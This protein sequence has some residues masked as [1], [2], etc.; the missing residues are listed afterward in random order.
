MKGETYLKELLGNMDMEEKA[1][2]LLQLTGAYYSGSG[3]ETGPE[4][5]M[6][7]PEKMVREAGSILNVSGASVLK[8]VQKRYLENS[9][10]KIPLLFMA[11]VINGYR[12]VMPIALAQSCTF[13]PELV[14]K[15]ARMA[16]REAAADGLHVT[17][18]PM[19]DLC[20]DARWG[21]VM[22]SSGEDVWLN[23][24]MTK[25][26]VEGYQGD[27]LSDKGTLASCPKH[28]AAYGAPEGGREYDSVDMSEKKLRE[29]YLEGY[30][31][32]VEAGCEMMMTSFNTLNGIP[33]SANKWLN[34]KILREEWGFDGVLISDYSAL[35]ELIVHGVAEDEEQAAKLA[36]EAGVD[37]DMVSRVYA[38]ALTRL[39]GEGKLQEEFLDEAVLR[40]LRLKDKLGLFENPYRYSDEQIEEEQACIG[41]KEHRDLAR[42]IAEE[43]FVLL[44]NEGILPI[45]PEK[46]QRIALIGPYADVRDLCGSWSI[47]RREEDGISLKEAMKN[48]YG[49]EFVE[50][51]QG[52]F[53]LDEEEVFYSFRSKELTGKGERNEAGRTDEELLAEAMKTAKKADVIVV[54]IGEH[55]QK[56]GEGSAKSSLALP[57]CQ[58]E[59]LKAAASLGKP[60]AA[61]VFSGRPVELL[62]VTQ[63]ADAVLMAWFPGTEGGPALANVISG[64][65][66]PSGRLSMSIPYCTG[67]EPIAYCRLNTGRPADGVRKRFQTG[68]QD[69]PNTPLFPFGSGLSYTSFTYTDL[70]ADDSHFMEN[71]ELIVTGKVKNTGESEGTEVVQCYVRDVIGSTSR[72]V[73]EL[74]AAERIRLLPGEEKAFSFRIPET[75]LRFITADGTFATEPG[76]YRIFVGPLEKQVR[77]M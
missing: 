1:A 58:I 61:V 68:Y 40:I 6:Q 56:S 54:A 25:A 21:R 51:A 59:L 4:Q 31:A 77:R 11:D 24:Q 16:A 49:A 29:E 65:A 47:Y 14:K 9:K 41:G 42:T 72:P 62:P 70:E 22:E 7:I 48:C 13:D 12:T 15:G 35:A 2:Q 28:F 44:K 53:L 76:E 30:H 19:A 50:S 43:S 63:Y 32:A 36:M 27:S 74:K 33:A 73:R 45:H 46:K 55:Q 64:K 52:S 23:R 3:I 39:I 17:F 60:V 37:M 38:E 67:Q 66:N 34:R 71:G 20:R 57:K 75:D 26:M 18:S 10:H 69:V 8:T 5:R